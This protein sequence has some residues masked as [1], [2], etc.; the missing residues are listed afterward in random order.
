MH[1]HIDYITIF[2]DSCNMFIYIICDVRFF[3]MYMYISD[4]QTI[5]SAPPKR[6]EAPQLLN[7][8]LVEGG[9][10]YYVCM[11]SMY[12]LYKYM[13]ICQSIYLSIDLFVHPPIHLSVCLS[14]YLSI[15]LSIYLSIYLI[16]LRGKITD[17]TRNPRICKG[18]YPHIVS[19]QVNCPIGMIIPTLGLPHGLPIEMTWFMKWELSHETR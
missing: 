9:V 15:D 14:I 5:P 12:A 7:S 10:P 17:V 11:H 16:Q 19:S 3:L 2:V 4:E 18:S 8:A 6:I 13:Y 1:N